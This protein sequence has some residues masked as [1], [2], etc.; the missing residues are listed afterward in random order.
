M[1]KGVLYV[2]LFNGSVYCAHPIGNLP[3]V[4]DKRCND[5]LEK[6]R[7]SFAFRLALDKREALEKNAIEFTQKPYVL[8]GYPHGSG[9]AE[10]ES[11][12]T[13]SNTNVVLTS[14]RKIRE[15]VWAI[16][17]FNNT[18]NKAECTCRVFGQEL[19]L[20][21]GKYEVKTLYYEN[22]VLQEDESMIRL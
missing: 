4:D 1:E 7:H 2:T 21:F 14:L 13:L 9:K 5:Y 3:I 18:A 6:G 17:L 22:G 10:R 12:V 11:V 19:A 16:R 15:N 8:N 20:S